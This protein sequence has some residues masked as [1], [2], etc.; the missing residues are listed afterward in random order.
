[1]RLWRRRRGKGQR[2]QEPAAEAAATPSRDLPAVPRALGSETADGAPA[3]RP[4]VRVGRSAVGAGGSVR[5]NAIGEGS[6]ATLIE[7]LVVGLPTGPQHRRRGQLA[8]PPLGDTAK[9]PQVS[10]SVTKALLSREHEGRAPVVFLEGYGGIGKTTLALQICELPEVARR[11]PGGVIWTVVGQSRTGPDLANHIA[12]ICEHLSG[13]RPTTVDPTL[14]GAQLGEILDEGEPALLV[15][16]DVWTQEQVDA[17]LV[18][19]ARSARLFTA[20]NM[21]LARAVAETVEVEQMTEDEARV[22]ASA[23]L[24]VL[25]AAVLD[26]LLRF[27]KGWPVLLGLINASLRAHVRAGGPPAEVAA[28]VAQLVASGGPEALDA[29]VSPHMRATVG[30]TVKASLDLLSADERERYF[31][32]AVF[33]E[34]AEVPEHVLALVWSVTGGLEHAESRRMMSLLSSLRLVSERWCDG[35]PAFAVHDVLR[36]CVRHQLPEHD[37]VSRNQALVRALRT[38]LPEGCGDHWWLLPPRET[39][40][41]QH[42]PYHLRAAQAQAELAALACDPRWIVAQIRYLGSAVPVVAALSGMDSPRATALREVL[43]RDMDIF[44]PEVAPSAVA[45]TLAS[46]L[47]ASPE[48]RDVAADCLDRLPRPLLRPHWP[49]PDTASA[50]LDGHTGPIGDCAVSPRGDTIATAS[51]DRLVILWDPATLRVRHVLR[52]H[53]ERVRACAFSPDG[54]L[55]L[56]AS[57][58]GT[59]RVWRV[60]DGHPVHVLGERAARALGCAWSRDG[61]WVAAAAGD[62]TVTVWSAETGETHQ[63]LLS[64]SGNEWDCAFTVD[65][66]GL[67]SVGEDGVLRAWDVAG[68]ALRWSR[69]MHDGR[70]RC[71]TF[72]PSGDL[73]ATAS[74]DTTVRLSRADG[75]PVHIL[76]GHTERVRFC[77]FSPDGAVLATASEDRTI[78]LW[79]TTSGEALCTLGGHTDWVGAAVFLADGRRLVSCGG[80]TTM[81]LWD[82]DADAPPRIVRPGRRAAGCCAFSPDGR[83]I[84]AGHSDGLVRL[85]DVTTAE[86]RFETEGHDG[87]VLDCA[88]TP[89]GDVVTAGGDGEL[90][91]WDVRTGERRLTFARHSGRIWGCEVSADGTRMASAGEDGVVRIHDLRNGDVLNEMEHRTGHA[92]GC[93]FSPDDSLLASV[94]DDGRLRLWDS[95][96]G[97]LTATLET[98]RELSLWSCRFSPDGSRLASVGT[99]A[100]ALALWSTADRTVDTYIPIGGDRI[101]GCA[102]SPSGRQ[103]A[104]CGDEGYLGVWDVATGEPLTGIRVAFPL[105]RCA[106]SAT[107]SG[108]V[109]AAAGNGGLYVFAYE[110]E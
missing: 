95:S 81:R 92:L 82:L 54:A 107:A 55:L 25:D 60:S 63:R 110:E 69:A 72:S 53:S 1:M 73:I 32:L 86:V 4:A 61:R 6:S 87:R 10:A 104:T 89:N 67:L 105:N 5:G 64:P 96:T 47:A 106:W 40:A 79:D 14:V 43:D 44:V 28:W 51:D 52:G 27:A 37:L 49:L 23:G 33:D 83:R 97:E 56:S 59:V 46:R 22:T 29:T 48:L 108:S 45:A 39:F 24:P 93:V 36:S 84:L 70:I 26:S 7:Q 16:D 85:L 62:G 17:F 2:P 78:R 57:T 42:L 101:T 65:G 13:H 35:E 9:R 99:P 19:G 91:L 74:S 109:L 3:N 38:L 18:G 90:A 15:V 58:D 41:L 21:G 76:R 50:S 94:G 68:G 100:T 75:E 20:R 34:D 102:F 71:C 80:D 11:F 31:D 66:T 8:P 98:G 77:G 88:V 103:I 12:D 30:A